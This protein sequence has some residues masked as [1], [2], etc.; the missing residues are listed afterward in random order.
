MQFRT[1]LRANHPMLEALGRLGAQADGSE[2]ARIL[3]QYAP[4]WL[5]QLPTMVRETELEHLQRRIQG[6]TPTRMVRELCE[7]VV[8]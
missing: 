4:L 8:F 5:L 7:A 2:I 3:R 6:T 1:R